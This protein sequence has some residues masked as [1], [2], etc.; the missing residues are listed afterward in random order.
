M[1][2]NKI[3]RLFSLNGMERVID[4]ILRWEK[5]SA[6]EK[7][8]AEVARNLGISPQ[9]LQLW[10]KRDVP[11]NRLEQLAEHYG[12]SIDVLTGRAPEDDHEFNELM[13]IWK[14]LVPSSRTDLIKSARYIRTIQNPVGE[15]GPHQILPAATEEEDLLSPE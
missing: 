3:N 15:T 4:R 1:F 5:A 7:A 11:G 2:T 6:D 9:L 12:C 14:K 13:A 10:K 8:L